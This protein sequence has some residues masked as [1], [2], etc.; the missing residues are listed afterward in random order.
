MP[1]K[2]NTFELDKSVDPRA[3]KQVTD[4]SNL[5]SD[6]NERVNYLLNAPEIP[7]Y[8]RTPIIAQFEEIIKMFN[9][10]DAK[11]KELMGLKEAYRAVL[12]DNIQRK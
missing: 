11:V 9:G 3:E 8:L 6:I 7:E 4:V 2:K 5:P 12:A 10:A 1:A